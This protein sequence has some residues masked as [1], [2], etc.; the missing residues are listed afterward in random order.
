MPFKKRVMRPQYTLIFIHRTY[1]ECQ[2]SL[3]EK[4]FQ[5][6]SHFSVT[7]EKKKNKISIKVDTEY[8]RWRFQIN[9]SPK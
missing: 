9:F 7:E 3:S 6:L 2:N 5:G 1:W 4:L 8:F